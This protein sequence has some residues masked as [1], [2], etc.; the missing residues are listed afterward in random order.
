MKR[1]T[2]A[3]INKTT[4]EKVSPGMSMSKG[5]VRDE[6]FTVMIC[7]DSRVYE[8]SSPNNRAL[9]IIEKDKTKSLEDDRFTDSIYCVSK[10]MLIPQIKV[11][12]KLTQCR[13]YRINQLSRNQLAKVLS[14]DRG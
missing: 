11:L 2:F 7:Q 14:A 5:S 1:R 12:N 10:R 6:D 8:F 3:E 9:V 4:D 13:L